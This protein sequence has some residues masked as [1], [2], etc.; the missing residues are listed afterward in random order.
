MES[1]Q[2]KGEYFVDTAGDYKIAFFFMERYSQ[3]LIA[4]LFFLK[5]TDNERGRGTFLQTLL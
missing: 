3:F 2:Q 5:R 1:L 4:L